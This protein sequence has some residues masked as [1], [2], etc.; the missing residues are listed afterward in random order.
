MSRKHELEFIIT[1]GAS[2]GG[3]NA[4]TEVVAQLPEEI[5]AA[6]FIVIH[7]SKVGLGD[8][9]V[10]RLQKYTSYTCKIAKNGENIEARHIYI[11]PPDEHL[12]V[13]ENEVIIGQG[14]AENRWRP[15]I[16]VLFRSAAAHYGSR[17]IGIVLT[18]YLNDG[19]SGMS[20]IKRSGGYCIVQDPTQAEYPDMPLSVLEH[21]EVDYCVP[22]N[23]MGE[24]IK[25]IIE[26]NVPKINTVP[27]EV[28]KEA[29][30]AEKVVTR[31]EMSEGLGSHSHYAC[32]DC[33]GGLHYVN[34]DTI[35]RYRCHVGHAYTENDLII[36]QSEALEATLWVALRMMEERRSLLSRI[37]EDETKKG[38]NRIAQS[39][40]QRASDLEKHIE[41]LKGVLFSTKKI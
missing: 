2:A 21:I 29:E 40:K 26:N 15:S 22:L 35:T 32:P 37:S 10:H 7:L 20:A 31:L 25:T 19:T 6:V 39:N 33:G 24:T 4:M 3:L 30:I 8:F 36:K 23:K 27:D 12:L 11:A 38:L 17:V 34:N 5:K 14:P 9:L 16:D 28:S 41:T 18:G 1:I 13:T